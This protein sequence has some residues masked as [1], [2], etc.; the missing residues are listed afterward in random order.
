MGE[1]I[2]GVAMNVE[3]EGRGSD[4]EG[5]SEDTLVSEES[6]GEQPAVDRVAAFASTAPPIPRKF[7]YWVLA[8]AAVLGLGGLGL[9]H[10]FSAAGI[11]PVPAARSASV[12][13]TTRPAATPLPSGHR[14]QLSASLPAFMDLTS[15]RGTPA[16]SIDL[17][18]QSGQPYSLS[19]SAT[20][21]TVLTFF[22]GPCN[23]ICPVMAAEIAQADADL[24][25]EAAHV[26]FVTVN[27]DPSALSVSG[28]AE[29]E[30]ASKL[31]TLPNWTMLTGS[32]SAMD[33]VWKSYG[34]A[35]TVVQKTGAE[36]HNNF[37]YFI[38]P[39]GRE[40]YRAAPFA[41]ESRSGVYSLPST[42]ID[43]WATGIAVYAVKVTAP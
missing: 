21:A 28:L 23:D 29:A 30:A 41:N 7:V 3:V 26:E 20:E 31:S 40:I 32:F 15:M 11:N 4:P 18:D 12:T 39:Q 37:V 10:L 9:E 13:T 22:N 16:P 24:G 1:A 8:G 2:V 36:A 38:D 43:H 19:T 14:T 17:I 5:R 35:I 27:T 33:A 25:V 34:I 42:D 6:T